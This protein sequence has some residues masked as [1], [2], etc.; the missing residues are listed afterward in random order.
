MR[1]RADRTGRRPWPGPATPPGP[2]RGTRARWPSATASRGRPAAACR[3]VV[4]A[5]RLS[6]DHQ[7]PST[8][9]RG[10]FLRDE[11]QRCGRQL[12]R[13]EVDLR[14][15]RRLGLGQQQ[16][17]ARL[18]RRRVG[19]HRQVGGDELHRSV[20]VAGVD[21]ARRRRSRRGR[22]RRRRAVRASRARTGSAGRPHRAP[23][24]A[25]PRRRPR[26]SRRW[27]SR[28]RSRP[29]RAGRAP[30]TC[31]GCCRPE[32]G[33]VGGVQ[34]G[35]FA[36]EEVVVDRLGEQGMAERI[37]RLVARRRGSRIRASTAWRRPRSRSG[38][39]P[40]GR[41]HPGQQLVG[42]P[43][44]GH[45]GGADHAAGRLVE[46]V[47]PDQEQVGEVDREGRGA[48][49]A[50]H[51]AELLDE[52]RVAVGPGDDRADLLVGER[53][54]VQGVDQGPDRRLGQRA[55]LEAVE[56]RGAGTTP[57]G[58]GAAGGGGGRR[59]CGRTRR[60]RRGP[61]AVGRRGS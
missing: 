30:R 31:R 57:R 60:A 17:G 24:R 25:S 38:V 45:R 7:R 35:A 53:V 4:P 3:V 36:G 55:D 18:D 34:A 40:R 33:D 9:L 15:E 1:R 29:A 47:Q 14:R 27:P 51:P 2:V 50:L 56:G 10:R 28:C 58:S 48:G 32:G 26:C 21:A 16:S 13:V 23:P 11:L 20:G 39:R 12:E 49:E 19:Q 42:D 22:P 37:P 46:P 61:R 54:G 59:R 8:K 52:E 43:A 41:E 6:V 44:P 5:L